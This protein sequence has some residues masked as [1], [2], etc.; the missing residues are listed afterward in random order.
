LRVLSVWGAD[1]HH[2]EMDQRDERRQDRRLLA[3]VDGCGARENPGV[4][5]SSS[6]E[7]HLLPKW[8]KVARQRRQNGVKVKSTRVARRASRRWVFSTLAVDFPSHKAATDVV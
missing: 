1:K 8:F 4:P 2:A 3:P 6:R 7:S 5:P